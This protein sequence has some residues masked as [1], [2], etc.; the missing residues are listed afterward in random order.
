MVAAA[1]EVPQVVIDGMKFA[2][3]CCSSATGEAPRRISMH[4]MTLS[5]AVG[6]AILRHP[7]VSRANAFVSRSESEV[8][9]AQ[10]AWYPRIDYGIRPGYG[11]S[12]GSEGNRTVVRSSVGVTQLVYD[13]G[14]TASRI[15]AADATLGQQRHLLADTVETVAYNTATTFVE[16]A[17]SQ[18]V[19]DAARRQVDALRV[20]QGR[21]AERV[22]AGLSVT[23]DHNLADI[24]IRRA[25][26]EVL[27]ARTRFDVAVVRLTELTG[28]R[29]QGVASLVATQG[30]VGNLMRDGGDIGRTPSV[31]AAGAALEAADAKLELAR[32]ERF[33]SVAVGVNRSLSTGPANA[34]NDTWVGVALTGNVSLGGLAR[35]QIDAAQAERRA[36]ADALENQRLVTRMALDSAQAEVS[37]AAARLSGYG[38]VIDLTRASRDLYWQEYTLDKRPLTEVVNP[39]REIFLA[40][41][42]WTNAAADGVLAGI[43]TLAAVGRFVESLRQSEGRRDE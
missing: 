43:K 28:V 38:K 23:S 42:E 39:E 4:R 8:A 35:H 26:A 17:V 30:V 7:D 13:F 34:T 18:D 24:A 31:L 3:E 36:A 10:A 41:V 19:M 2:L 37:G 27:K 9:V 15:S 25:E 12:F 29:P 16:L 40:E 14:R 22:Q 32:A 1:A 21:I 20:I 6:L 11:G 5:E 33:P